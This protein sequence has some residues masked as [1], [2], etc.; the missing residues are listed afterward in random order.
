MRKSFRF[1]F[2]AG[3]VVL[4][5]ILVGVWF[6]ATNPGTHK[7]FLASAVEDALGARPQIGEFRVGLDGVTL[8]DFQ[9]APPNG[10]VISMEAAVIEV[11]V[12]TA[13]M[14]LG[15]EIVI[16]S[17]EV[18]GLSA[19]LSQVEPSATPPAKPAEPAPAVKQAE[20]LHWN[21]WRL[22]GATR[23][24]K[25]TVGTIAIDASIHLLAGRSATLQ[26]T[27]GGIAPGTTGQVNVVAVYL[28][29]SEEAPLSRAHSDLVLRLEQ[30]TDPGI[31]SLHLRDVLRLE[32]AAFLTPVEARTDIDLAYEGGTE[33]ITAAVATREVGADW[34]EFLTAN[35]RINGTLRELQG[36][37]TFGVR[38]DDLSALGLA[39][40]LAGYAI[41]GEGELFLKANEDGIL[42]TGLASNEVRIVR[43]VEGE[44]ARLVVA[45]LNVQVPERTVTGDY[46]IN[47]P[48]EQIAPLAPELR[49][50]GLTLNA[51]G[52]LE[53]QAQPSGEIGSLLAT[54]EL[55]MVSPDEAGELVASYVLKKEADA[56]AITLTSPFS[57]DGVKR[58]SHLQA[59]VTVDLAAVPMFD[60]RLTGD[61]IDAGDFQTFALSL[62]PEPAEPADVE[63]ETEAE[64]PAPEEDPAP[65]PAIRFARDDVPVWGATTLDATV[66]V[67]IL[68]LPDGLPLL[69]ADIL[70]T[71]RPDRAALENFFLKAASGT[72]TM[73]GEVRFEEEEE[74]PYALTFE[75]EV[76]D[77][78]SR[79][80][81][82]TTQGGRTKIRGKYDVTARASGRGLNPE[83]LV[84]RLEGEVRVD[85]RDGLVH[86]IWTEKDW[87]RV[88]EKEE[89]MVDRVFGRFFGDDTRDR[90]ADTIQTG[91]E[92][93]NK[94]GLALT[95]FEYEVLR[96]RASRDETLDVFLDEL[97]L[98]SGLL[99]IEATG[100]VDY[101]DKWAL[102]EMPFE[103]PVLLAARDPFAGYMKLRLGEETVTEKS[104]QGWVALREPITIRGNA[105][106]PD[107]TELDRLVDRLLL[108][109]GE[110]D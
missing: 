14:S 104:P 90:M 94:F 1:G 28:D 103:V 34:R 21:E 5:L 35:H 76:D 64:T 101:E 33:T 83:H 36:N 57:L 41:E 110:D 105:N 70:A 3:A 74:A 38:G 87:A 42:T 82:F 39:E 32:G 72:V 81:M 55:T 58:D 31:T 37:Y 20:E 92:M 78:D 40:R 48:G 96:V 23:V 88:E 15:K 6:W 13:V 12:W 8:R 26:V 100:T 53:A 65:A 77:F 95:D 49:L 59:N 73:S 18:R 68:Y 97:Y 63:E 108:G 71:V 62:L 9:V 19:D 51:H 54:G 89:R 27:G 45:H 16:D 10:A 52:E 46:T 7:A 29:D 75:A 67:S 50:A 99:R 60:V 25:L 56:T 107:T 43:E 30:G 2:L 106:E 109:G 4:L 84:T 11:S 91:V 98:Q 102:T 17:V 79:T 61:V 80:Y 93:T 85:S 86:P 44:T 69:D 47:L 24:P 22:L 66:N